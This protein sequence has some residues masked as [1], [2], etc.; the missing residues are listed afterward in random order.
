MYKRVEIDLFL[1]YLSLENLRFSGMGKTKCIE[2]VLISAF[3]FTWKVRVLVAQSCL[4]LFD[5][6]DCSPPGSSVHGIL[7]TRIL[8]CVAIPF[9][10]GSSPTQGLN[11]C[12]LCLLH[13]KWILYHLSHQRNPVFL[14][15]TSQVIPNI[16]I[17]V[18]KYF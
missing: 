5:P 13:C 16:F 3:Y 17:N 1:L 4:T 14:Q 12:L 9:S 8:G 18:F 11:P 6:V 2:I 7:Q 10:R 15:R